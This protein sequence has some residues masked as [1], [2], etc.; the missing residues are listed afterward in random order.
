[1][2]SLHVVKNKFYFKYQWKAFRKQ[3]WSTNYEK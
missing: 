1:M 2:Y 3:T